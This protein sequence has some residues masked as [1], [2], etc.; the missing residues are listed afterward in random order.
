MSGINETL[1]V[2]RFIL[3]IQKTAGAM[4]YVVQ[5]ITPKQ[6]FLF[7]LILLIEL[8]VFFMAI[9]TFINMEKAHNH[10]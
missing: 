1:A 9:Y 6:V 10:Q 4:K 7:G 3:P 2:H 5:K 8:K